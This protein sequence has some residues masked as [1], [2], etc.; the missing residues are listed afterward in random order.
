MKPEHPEMLSLQAQIDELDKQI[1]ARKR[2]NVVGPQQYA[3]SPII[4]RALSAEQALQARVD[5]LK[6]AVLNLRGRSIQYNILQREVDTNRS[7]YDALAPALQGDRRRRR[8]R[9]GA[10]VDRRPRRRPGAAVQAEPA[11]QPARSGLA[12]GLLA[13]IGAAIGLEF[14]NDTIKTREDVRNKL[15]LACLGAVPEDGRARTRSSRS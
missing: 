12:G 4:A 13:G 15:G 6:G 9:H 5:Q 10:G 2:A 3:C 14:V 1:A 7:L 8:H 11:A